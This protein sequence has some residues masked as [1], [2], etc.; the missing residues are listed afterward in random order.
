MP[1]LFLTAGLPKGILSNSPCPSVVSP[2]VTAQ[3]FFLKLCVKL[4]HHKSTR[5]LGRS[6]IGEN[7]HFWDIF[8]VFCQYVKN[9]S[10]DF[11]EILCMISPH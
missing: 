3:R 1:S 8:G 11:D 5:N 6:Q 4:E 2:S 9:G 7:P 10:K